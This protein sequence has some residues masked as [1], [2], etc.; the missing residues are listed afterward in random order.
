MHSLPAF[1][2]ASSERLLLAV[3]FERY[4]SIQLSSLANF[5]PWRLAGRV[6]EVVD[7]L[8]G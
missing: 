7:G 4:A 2:L 3:L 5:R 6:S 8:G 1:E